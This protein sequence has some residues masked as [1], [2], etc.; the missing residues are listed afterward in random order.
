MAKRK[1]AVDPFRKAQ[2]LRRRIGVLAKRK[3]ARNPL[4]GVGQRIRAIRLAKG[5]TLTELAE[6]CP[7][8]KGYLSSIERG[9]GKADPTLSTLARIATALGV[10]LSQI[11]TNPDVVGADPVDDFR[12][13]EISGAL[14]VL[15]N[16]RK[17]WGRT[18]LRTA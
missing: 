11:I 18:P 3:T 16:D 6:G 8:S 9:Y 7:M 1:S 12:I 14:R 10:T 13:E 4:D 2:T 17:L 5:F 15:I